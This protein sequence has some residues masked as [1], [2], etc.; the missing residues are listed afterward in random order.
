MNQ[1]S[2]SFSSLSLPMEDFDLPGTLFCGQSFSWEDLGNGHYLGVAGSRAVR[3]HMDGTQ[4][5]LS[6]LA[7]QTLTPEDEVFWRRYFATDIDY[8]ALADIFSRD[9]TL[10]QCLDHAQGLRVLRQPF[11]DTLLSFII[12][13]NNHIPR[14]TA[15]AKR[16]RETFG[17]EI[18]PGVYGFPTPERLASLSVEDLAPLRAGFRG[19]YLIDAARKVASGIVSEEMLATLSDDDARKHLMAIHGVGPKVA[20]CVLLYSQGRNA[21]IPMDVWMK[22]AMAKA[23]PEGM[24]KEAKGY[25]GIA[26][27][28]IFCWAREHL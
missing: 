19:K 1:P 24:P 9:D 17:S 27:Q 7:P 25:E 13:Q 11:F 12:S 21:I 10:A 2:S 23:F 16:L 4:L 5:V 28:Y 26:Q 20:D 14:I 15:I 8:V 3:A 6:P 18:A 22:R